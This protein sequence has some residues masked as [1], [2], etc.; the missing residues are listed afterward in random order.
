[1]KE[2]NEKTSEANNKETNLKIQQENK[3]ITK[4]T[5]TIQKEEKNKH[6]QKNKH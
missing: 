5:G 1:M 2:T 3:L 4:K 6:Q